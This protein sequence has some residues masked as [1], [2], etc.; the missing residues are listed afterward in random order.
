MAIDQINISTPSTLISFTDTVLGNAVDGVKAS[1]A[2]LYSVIVDNSANGGAAS[3][4]KIFNATTGSIT[5]GTTA[6]DIIIYV[7]GGAILTTAFFTGAVQGVTLA[8]ALSVA[9]VTTGGTAGTTS[10]SSSVAVT[11]NYV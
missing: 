5:L 11:I 9:C 10:P 4:V 6:P 2:K 1:S 8:T 7:P 3:Y